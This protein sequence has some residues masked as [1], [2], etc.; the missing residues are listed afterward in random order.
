[1]REGYRF[2]WCFI[3]HTCTTYLK[4]HRTRDSSGNQ[5]DNNTFIFSSSPGKNPFTSLLACL[6]PCIF[7]FACAIGSQFVKLLVF[8]WC[9]VF[10][11]NYMHCTLF[12]SQSNWR[13]FFNFIFFF[14]LFFPHSMGLRASLLDSECQLQHFTFN[15]YSNSNLIDIFKMWKTWPMIFGTEFRVYFAE[16]QNTIYENKRQHAKT[17]LY[18]CLHLAK[19]F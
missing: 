5:A 1:M 11:M 14:L 12:S 13:A 2:L 19:F 8:M 7:V 18:A 16:K 10:S 15:I 9:L 4:C 3:T 6:C 17:T